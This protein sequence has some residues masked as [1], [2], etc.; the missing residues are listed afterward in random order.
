MKR[1]AFLQLSL[2][3]CGSLLAPL[4][5]GAIIAEQK[6]KTVRA[7]PDFELD[8]RTIPEL[9]AGMASGRY[10]AVSLARKYFERIDKVDHQGPALRAVM[11]LNPDALAI[12]R[13]L[14]RER[15]AGQVRSQLH[16]IPVLIKDNIDTHDRMTCTAGSL[17]LLGSH[18]QRDAF[19]VQKLRD[20]GAVI[21]GKTNLSEWANFRG[22]RSTSGWSGR[23]GQTRNPYALDHNPSGSSSGS[24]VGVAANLCAVAVGTE[25]NGS[26]LS[27]ASYNGIVGIKPTV[28]LVSR[29]GVIPI[30]QN[31]DTAG[32]MARTV[33]DAAILLSC[34]AAPDSRDSGAG[35]PRPPALDTASPLD[36]THTLDS[37]GLR[38]A[39]IGV[40]R[41]F[42]RTQLAAWKATQEQSLETLKGA[43]AILVDPVELPEPKDA[44]LVMLY[45]FK[46]GLNAYL[47]N[48]GPHAPLR[49]LK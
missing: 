33:T 16:G 43:G 30:A 7:A 23:G 3:G 46:D 20:A 44:Y 21:L 34:L 45:E 18:P 47:S 32:P 39:R 5:A 4:G 38:G 9:Q 14:D 27:P 28:G 37:N 13:E 49:S 10:S 48:L 15:K 42:F 8:E 1:R 29:C 12:A 26:I 35:I 17:A 40:A 11:E 19:L 31:Q 25:T 22:A 6:S 2:A 24:A 36:Y 41:K